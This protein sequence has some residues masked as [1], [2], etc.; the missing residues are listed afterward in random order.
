HD[1]NGRLPADILDKNGKP[2]LSWRVEI[3]P[4]IEQD[5]LYKLFKLDEPWDSEN[6]KAASQ[7]MIK[8][9]MSPNATRPDKFEWGMTSYRGIAGPG[10]AF[11]KGQKLKLTD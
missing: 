11:E 8:V 9:F 2:L 3:L 6:N 7:L 1:A 5:N 4:Y 10:A